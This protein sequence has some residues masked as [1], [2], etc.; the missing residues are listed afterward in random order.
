MSLNVTKGAR[1]AAQSIHWFAASSAVIASL[2]LLAGPSSAAPLLS[3]LDP[4]EATETWSP[5]ALSAD[6]STVVGRLVDASGRGRAA[7]W[8]AAA[9]LVTLPG[10]DSDDESAA[11]GVSGDGS[12]IVGGRA[13]EAFVYAGS[14]GTTI[15]PALEPGGAGAR[16]VGVSDDGTQF[17]GLAHDGTSQTD[18][19]TGGPTNDPRFV[20][21]QWISAAGNRPFE[22]MP[23]H[24][25]DAAVAND[26]TLVASLVDGMP[27]G[28]RQGVRYSTS[29]NF[30][31]FL[32]GFEND[33]AA[34][35]AQTAMALSADGST[36]VGSALRADP[37][38][39][40]RTRTGFR[41]RGDVTRHI[42]PR[43]GLEAL[44]PIGDPVWRGHHVDPLDVSPDGETIVGRVE[45]VA[46][47]ER[48]AF[49]WTERSGLVDLNVLLAAA[50]VDL[51][52]WTLVEA[53]Q[54]AGDGRR[55]LATAHRDG[56]SRSVLLLVPEPATALL[57]GLGLFG[58]RFVDDRRVSLQNW[59]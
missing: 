39:G 57:L 15:L 14:G 5:Y 11:Y 58:L 49:L 44:H 18:P 38:S 34:E 8:T 21:V 48:R 7:R 41:W 54:V 22:L 26:G 20:V 56:V 27:S 40:E 12:V 53:L 43:E 35:L 32:P 19:A 47:G 33:E 28:D 37:S 50:G 51:E 52:G 23:F 6:G 2:L 3:W 25:V 42:L 36:I 13:G 10:F 30:F 4:V 24:A 46:D 45:R 29:D 55:L 1:P 17:V 9:G 59:K 31:S 16:V